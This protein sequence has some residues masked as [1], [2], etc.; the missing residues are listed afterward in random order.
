MTSSRKK[1]YIIAEIGVNH[2][3]KLALAK[4][5][6]LE[7]KKA[8]ADAVKFQNFKASNLTTKNAKKAPYQLKNTKNAQTQQKM[9]K[10]LELKLKDYF[11]LKKF[12]KKN[13][14]DF[15]T[16][17]FDEESIDFLKNKLKQNLIKIPS[18]ELNNVLIT[19]KLNIKD[20]KIILSTGMANISEIAESLNSILK[21]K[22]YFVS[23]NRV[24]ILNHSFLNK[25]RKKI[26]LLHCVTDYPVDLKFANLN[27]IKTLSSKF[28]IPIGYSDHTPGINAPLVAASLGA[29]MIEKHFTLNKNMNGPDHKASLEP[30]EFAL[31]VQNIRN[32][33]IMLG[34]G[35]KKVEKCERKNINIARKS[36][37]AKKNIGKGEKFSKKN[38]TTKRPGNGLSP[39]KIKNLIGKKSRYNFKQDNLIKI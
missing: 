26:T 20:Y 11:F 28:K 14:I 7:A 4:K 32:F 12:S 8:G 18:G 36:I 39:T 5:M 37:I 23:K 15:F 35:V 10:K 33:E 3:G 34:D 13:R 31:M 21:K 16:S 25:I 29:I 24:K 9:L 27:C 30:N 38:L 6:I 17:V 22:I 19:E 2:N 1:I